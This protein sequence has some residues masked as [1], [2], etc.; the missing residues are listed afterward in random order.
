[1]VIRRLMVSLGIGVVLVI[2]GACSTENA[3]TGPSL[4]S[5]QVGVAPGGTDMDPGREP[6]EATVLSTVMRLS[7]LDPSPA[8]TTPLCYQEQT[9]CS[10]EEL[11]AWKKAE[12][13]RLKAVK[14]ANKITGDSLK[15]VWDAFKKAYPK[16]KLTPFF[17]CEPQKYK[18]SL[19]IIGPEGGTMRVGHHELYIPPGALTQETV[20]TAERPVSV[21]VDVRLSPAGLQFVSSATLTL[22]YK[23]CREPADFEFRVVYINEHYNILEWPVSQDDKKRDEVSAY[24]DHFSK[25]AVAY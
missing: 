16:K 8:T 3:P 19:K 21:L 23:H 2:V 22:D 13:D 20:I 11:D 10:K 17:F 5:G 12:K 25:Y 6:A 18:S 1:M 24:I 14:K 9:G 15:K 4:G 7:V